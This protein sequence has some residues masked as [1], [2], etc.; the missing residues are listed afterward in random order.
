MGR[1]ASTYHGLGETSV[2]I[3]YQ[4]PFGR[5]HQASLAPSARLGYQ[6]IVLPD[7]RVLSIQPG[8]AFATRDTGTD[9]PWEQA[10]QSGNVL[11]FTTGDGTES[12][13]VFIAER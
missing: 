4:D 11:V 3:I 12:Y 6:R 8:G 7:A 1:A 2:N 9:G 13:P 5:W 10:K